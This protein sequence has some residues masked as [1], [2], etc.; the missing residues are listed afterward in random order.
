MTFSL[1]NLPHPIA[2]LILAGL[3]VYI[4]VVT[5]NYSLATTMGYDEH[6]HLYVA[7]VS[8]LWKMVLAA[9]S[10]FHPPV[11]YLPLRLLTKM[12]IDPF[13]SRLAAVIP[14]ILSV[15]LWYFLL[16]KLRVNIPTALTATLVLATAY[17]FQHMGVLIRSYAPTAFLLLVGLWFWLD[18][19]PGTRGKPSR[20]SAVMSLLFFTLAI[21]FLYA[22]AFFTSAVF[23]A[24]LLVMAVNRDARQTIWD[25]WRRYSGF[26]EWFAFFGFHLLAILWFAMTWGVHMNDDIPFHV[27]QFGY[28][29]GEPMLAFLHQGMR[30]E[31]DLLTPLGT[32]GNLG[33]DIGMGLLL[34][35]I[36]T[37]AAINLRRGNSGAAVTALAA[38][39]LLAILA[40]LALTGKYPFGGELRHQYLMFPLLLLLLPLAVDLLWRWWPATWARAIIL[41]TVIGIALANAYTVR[42]TQQVPEAPAT[43]QWGAE[44]QALFSHGRDE[45][46]LVN[47]YV[48]YP[49]Y[50]NRLPHGVW[51][52]SSYQQAPQ[53]YYTPPQDWSSITAPWTPYEEYGAYSDDDQ[54]LVFIRDRYRFHIPPLADA[55][56]FAQMRG[57]LKA[58]GKDTISILSTQ[59]GGDTV[60]SEKAMQDHAGAQGFELT[61]METVGNSVIWTIKVVG[62]APA[63]PPPAPSAN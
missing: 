25:N 1:R 20:W 50:T 59:G 27:S 36:A 38:A 42:Q 10:D 45:P 18:L 46:V 17:S 35:V 15:P 54:L 49:T 16:R 51:Y 28:Q 37:L 2:L 24:T 33:L 39:L 6:W 60:P 4:T 14:T 56:F 30:F 29:A 48:F 21:G 44:Y 22:A 47:A 9:S 26:P 57:I 7:T 13:W 32:L 63:E 34:V 19:L 61:K 43:E 40:L 62:E 58:M 52:R 41:L 23:G 12:G 8:P 5:I 53:G 55:V 3:T 11:Y 31:L